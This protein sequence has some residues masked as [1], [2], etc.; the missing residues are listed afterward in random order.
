MLGKWSNFSFSRFRS[1][2][3]GATCAASLI[4]IAFGLFIV[5]LA[6]VEKL[7]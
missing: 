3:L 6:I 1:P 7:S 2:H 4:G 5:I